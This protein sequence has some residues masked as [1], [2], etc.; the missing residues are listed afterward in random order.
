[1]MFLFCGALLEVVTLLTN[2]W[3]ERT[4][5]TY[6]GLGKTDGKSKSKTKI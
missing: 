2:Q 6:T 4:R 3:F 1:M 5:N